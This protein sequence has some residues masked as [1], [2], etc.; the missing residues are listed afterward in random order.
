MGKATIRDVASAA[1]V[2][3]QTVS[4]VLNERPDVAKETRDRVLQ[5]IEALGYHPSAIARSLTHQRT[6]TLGVVTAGLKFVGPSRTLNGIA[7]QAEQ[8]GFALLLTELPRFDTADVR[9]IVHALL[10]R[11][12][13]G[14]I[15][16]VPEV[17]NNRD[18][19]RSQPTGLTVP[20]VFIA[21]QPRADLRTVSVDNCHG[22][23]AATEHLLEQGYRRIAH[24]A[25]PLDWWEARQRKAGWQDALLAA[26][27]EVTDHQWRSGNWSSASGD[28]AMRRLLDGYPEM[29][30]VFVA[31]DQMALGALRV[32]CL[33]GMRV[34]QDLAMVGFDG[35]PEAAYYCP[36]L[37]TVYQDQQ[38]VGHIAVSELVQAVEAKQEGMAGLEPRTIWLEP[39]LTVRESSMAPAR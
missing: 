26:G 5:V 15:W 7:E 35:L 8:M 18:W 14:I 33:R 10:T 36:P 29:D 6:L 38:K 37:T 31:N 9:S 12:V 1:G 23:R 32:L 16:A 20:T 25:G 2:S 21:M 17:G 39:K 27:L 34:P 22:A 30:A 28:E 3:R 19:L 4:R 11:Q 13:D 24:L